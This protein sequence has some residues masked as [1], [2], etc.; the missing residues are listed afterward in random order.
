MND[1]LG[2]TFEYSRYFEDPNELWKRA[3]MFHETL[4][5]NPDYIDNRIVLNVDERDSLLTITQFRDSNTDIWVDHFGAN[6]VPVLRLEV[7]KDV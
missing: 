2:I 6:R 7:R 4:R 5:G 1:I 3:N